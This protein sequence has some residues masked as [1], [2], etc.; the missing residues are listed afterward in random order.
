MAIITATNNSFLQ[1]LIGAAALDSAIFWM[2]AA[3]VVAVRQALDYQSTSRAIA[4]CGVGWA[5]AIVIAIVLGLV[6]GPPLS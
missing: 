6:F 4:V 1:R 5:L 2:L 3:M